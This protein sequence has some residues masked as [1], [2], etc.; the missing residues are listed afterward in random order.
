[1][2]IDRY[3]GVGV[4][5]AVDLVNILVV[6]R[7]DDVVDR[8]RRVFAFDPVSA[9]EVE[10]RHSGPL[11][12]LAE[13]LHAVIGALDR[14]DQDAAAAAI[15]A[16]L[17]RSPAHPHLAKEGGSWTLHHH[18]PTTELVASW[19]A[20][21]GEGLARLVGAGFGERAHLCEAADC[22]R[23]YVDTTKNGTRRF[24]STTCQNRVKAAARR[25]RQAQE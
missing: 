22:R 9:A 5:V 23:A 1:M 6:D 19:T 17:D 18:P 7:S 13:E 4:T 12:S 3:V 15:N 8:L 21:C 24:C 16:L 14:G 25:R 11:A 10:D 2:E 20:I